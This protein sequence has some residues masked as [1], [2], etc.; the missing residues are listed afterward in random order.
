MDLNLLF[1]GF[2]EGI[3]GVNYGSPKYLACTAPSID[4]AFKL[5]IG[6]FRTTV[7]GGLFLSMPFSGPVGFGGNIKLKQ[8]EGKSFEDALGNYKGTKIGG[9]IFIAGGAGTFLKN[10]Q[11]VKIRMKE[12]EMLDIFSIRNMKYI[13]SSRHAVFLEECQD[14]YVIIDDTQNLRKQTDCVPHDPH[15]SAAPITSVNVKMLKQLRFEKPSP[16]K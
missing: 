1:V 8:L 2:Q 14:P 16:A 6:F 3:R 11:N 12:F 10:P 7:T 4:A 5:P 15:S 9:G 13:L